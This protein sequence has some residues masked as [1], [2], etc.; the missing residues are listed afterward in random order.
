MNENES[1]AAEMSESSGA[2]AGYAFDRLGE[3]LRARELPILEERRAYGETL[4]ERRPLEALRSWTVQEGRGQVIDLIEEQSAHRVPELVPLRY[5][6]MGVSPFTFYRGAAIVMAHDL[7]RMPAT[8]L[9]VQCV[10]DAH[11]ANFGLFLSP[12][13]HLVFDIND[14]DETAPGP[15]EWDILRL[16][17]SVEI[18]GRDRGFAKEERRDA[19]RACAK[20]YR[21]AMASFAAMGTLD[22]WHAHLDV[23]RA[24]DEFEV[25]GKRGRTIRRAVERARSKDSARAADRLAHEEEGSLRFNMRPPELVPLAQLAETQ[26]YRSSSELMTALEG[27]LD[28]YYE[29]LPLDRRLLLSRYRI[30]D[31]ARKVVGVGSVGTRAWVAL[32]TGK[33]AEDPL[34]MQV[35]EAGPSVIERF[36]KPAPFA[37]GGER[38]VQ[39]QRL[40]QST[41]DILLG[42]TG[43]TAPDGTRRTYYVRQLWNGKGS[44]DLEEIGPESLENTAR[45][46]AWALAHAHAR[47]G[48]DAA[49]AAYLDQ[50]HSFE[51]ALWEFAR[52]YAD[53]NEADYAV[54]MERHGG[55]MT[56]GRIGET[57]NARPP[58]GPA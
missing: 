48:D 14:F 11:I 51:D 50:K 22:V 6:R 53:Q 44:I 4:R 34:V 49:I 10:G 24:L 42:W 47:T 32:L 52:A 45:L 33:D 30:Q 12:T 39:G 17:A 5:E 55:C 3:T 20:Q 7:A 57:I 28:Q 18:C 23:E 36:Y 8:G 41:A 31:G 54:F 9:E 26:G 43:V 56:C 37:H 38:V 19:V 16:A 1:L 2:P 21:H 13:R 46:C 40:I 25:D 29:S 58:E 15:W 35:K 27:M